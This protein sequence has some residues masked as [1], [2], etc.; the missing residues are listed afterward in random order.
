MTRLSGKTL[1][2]CMA[3]HRQSDLHRALA[4][5]ER[6]E[7]LVELRLDHWEDSRESLAAAV[8]AIPHRLILTD[9]PP[10]QGGKS[11]RKPAE[12]ARLLFEACDW[13]KCAA[14]V[15]LEADAPFRREP[16]PAGQKI[17]SWHDFQETPRDP[18]ALVRRMHRD[19]PEALIKLA[20]TPISA[21]DFLSVLTLPA[22]VDFPVCAIAMGERGNLSRT[23]GPRLGSD[24]VYGSIPGEPGTAPGQLDARTLRELYRVESQGPETAMDAVVGSPL[25]HSLSPLLHNASHRSLELDRVYVSLETDALDEAL[26]L[27]QAVGIHG[28]SVTLPFKQDAHRVAA[29][30]LDGYQEF[31]NVGSANTLVN[32]DGNWWAAN[33]DAAGFLHALRQA[34]P[35]LSLQGANVLVLGAGGVARTAVAVLRQQGARV[36]VT[37]RTRR[38]ALA[39]ARDFGVRILPPSGGVLPEADVIVNATPVGMYPHEQES[40][41]PDAVLRKDQVVYDLVYRPRR[42][43]LLRQAQEAG[44]RIVDGAA[45]F[46]HQAALQVQLFTGQPPDLPA[47]EQALE[48]ALAEPT[49]SPPDQESP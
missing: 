43:R 19:L 34:A 10:D 48:A 15:D 29:G 37:S 25:Q 32:R 20:V 12:R 36:A 4:T 24:L 17:L 35:D 46:L 16:F 40:P 23:L 18:L 28:L 7:E 9:R 5:L 38:R 2:H 41:V 45:M 27:A 1:V 49:E 3:P 11:P 14:F 47:M 31:S 26:L 8:R 21:A 22:K 33:T 13:A 39:L 6:T 30:W 44:C 42:T